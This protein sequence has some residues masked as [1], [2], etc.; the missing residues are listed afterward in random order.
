MEFEFD[1]GPQ[2]T[3]NNPKT[4]KSPLFASVSGVAAPLSAE[5]VVFFNPVD[6]RSHVMTQQVLQALALSRDFQ[7]LAT[8]IDR[9]AH[10]IPALKPQRGA[11]ATVFE[12][13]QKKGAML[14]D[15]QWLQT[16][17]APPQ[18][19]DFSAA[20]TKAFAGLVVRT[21]DR[22]ENLQRF[23]ESLSVYCQR[24]N[25]RWPVHV[26]DDSR[27]EK[28]QKLNEKICRE[29]GL[30]VQHHGSVWQRSFIAMLEKE[31]PAHKAAIKWLL[32]R[33]ENG[34]P[35]TGGRSWNLALLALAGKKILFFDDDFLFEPRR[36]KQ[37]A[38]PQVDFSVDAQLSVSFGANL[39]E[40]RE[41]TEHVEA[42]V[43]SDLI[44]TVGQ[45]L[46]AWLQ[47]A[48]KAVKSLQAQPL[49]ELQ[50]LHGNSPIKLTG[51]G[52]WG[53]PRAE[54]NYWLYFLKGEQK[55]AFWHTRDSYL[56]HIEAS[57][58]LH[59]S[60]DY[61]TLSLGQFAPSA[62]DNTTL[63][64]FAMPV[65]KNEDHFF[66]GMMLFTYPDQVALHFPWMLGH[67]QGEKRRRSGMNHIAR[68]PN[69]N[70]FVTDYLLSKSEQCEASSP[71]QRITM[72]AENLRSLADADFRVLSNR[73]QEYMI[74]VRANIVSSLQEQLAQSPD[75]PIYWQA[76]VRELIE[77]N[78]KAL[79]SNEPPVFRGWPEDLDLGGCARRARHELKAIAQG[80]AVWP[81]LW[82][83]CHSH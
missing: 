47:Q 50:R 1:F 55:Q 65:D 18:T 48:P 51:N 78:G 72:A 69:F 40:I 45:P 25:H 17:Q 83:F 42:D 9:V 82:E 36:L 31:F 12:Y 41:K 77:A 53:S 7:P 76:D 75:A 57:H 5:E 80:L 6:G 16:L 23:L 37:A 52:T 59:Y 30:S 67:I 10:H 54:S 27:E 71:A 21:C 13:L 58:L 29:S 11:I 33:P 24:F 19:D 70:L 28:N 46:S 64:P 60:P 3:A 49:A 38:S 26:F 56:E 35:F 2:T 4:E 20:D 63:A 66:N 34:N 14:S 15:E 39:D 43:L 74:H 79:A 61:Q 44:A 8:H 68:R 22:P 81:R 32:D 62:I 73:L